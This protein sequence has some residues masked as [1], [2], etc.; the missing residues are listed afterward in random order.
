MLALALGLCACASPRTGPRAGDEGGDARVL[1]TSELPPRQRAVWESWQRG[2]ARWELEREEVRRDPELTRFLVDNL[3]RTLVKSYDRSALATAG[4]AS[5]PFE[6]AAAELCEF[7]AQ[8]TPVLV[9]L[10]AVRDGV[11]AFLAADLLLR[12]GVRAAPSIARLLNDESEETRRRAAEL[13]GKLPH[14]GEGEGVLEEALGARV[15]QD[16]AWIVR[17]EAAR[18]LGA[19]ASQHT[20]KGY[21]LGVLARA[22]G[23]PDEAVVTNACAG[24]ARLGERRAMPALARALEPAA[25]RGNVKAVFALQAALRAPLRPAVRPGSAGLAR[26]VRGPSAARAAAARAA[27]SFGARH[28]V[29]SPVMTSEWKFRGREGCCSSCKAEFPEGQRHAS[30]LA[31]VADEVRREDLCPSC[32]DARSPASE[33]FYWFT[34][35]AAGARGLVLDLVML[36]QL[37]LRLE[38]HAQQPVRELRFLVA[39]LLMRKRRLKLARVSR[40][41]TGEAMILR[42]P[43]RK[44]G[45]EVQVFDFG[46]ERLAELRGTLVEL[47]GGADPSLGLVESST[48][49]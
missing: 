34:R 19:R 23:D 2:G 32:F 21:A 9:E 28:A 18:A 24:L 8:S 46:P 47:L 30:V 45:F 4:K 7:E 14:A 16:K 22:L 38:G 42:R 26:L 15:A 44:E 40:G 6:R 33:L 37:F 43:R 27:L 17:A 12:I 39:L 11:V 29:H 36:E 35:R 10:L 31:V 48:E 13:L 49:A 20:H 25:R 1:P 41:A 5:G 3:V